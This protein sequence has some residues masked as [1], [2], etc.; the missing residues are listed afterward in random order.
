M[1][2]KMTAMA[3]LLAAGSAWGQIA[4]L[5]GAEVTDRTSTPER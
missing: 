3:L 2:A 5:D 4:N 1:K